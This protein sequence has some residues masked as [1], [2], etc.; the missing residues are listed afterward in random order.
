MINANVPGSSG[1]DPLKEIVP[2]A[3]LISIPIV[4][5]TNAKTGPKI[6]EGTDRTIE[7]DNRRV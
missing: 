4:L 1:Y 5:V 6:R 3:K 7:S 2:V